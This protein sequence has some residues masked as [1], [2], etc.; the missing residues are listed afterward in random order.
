MPIHCTE[1][2]PWWYIHGEKKEEYFIAEV[3]PKVAL[4]AERN[5]EKEHDRTAPDLIVN[6]VVADLK[7]QETPFFTCDR[8]SCDISSHPHDPQ[9]AVTFNRGDYSKYKKTSPEIDIYFWLNWQKLKYDHRPPN[10]GTSRRIVV[11]PMF[12]VYRVGFKDLAKRIE[13]GKV[14]LH[15]YRRRVGDPWNEKQSYVFDVRTFFKIAE[16]VPS[17]SA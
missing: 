8:Y 2:A 14:P 5:P 6:G 11:K 13:A 9:Y 1:D 17:H 16:G 7:T 3:A 10:G 4:Q 12:G 15:A